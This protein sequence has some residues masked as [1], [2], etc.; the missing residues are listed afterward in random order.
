[1]PMFTSLFPRPNGNYDYS[2]PLHV[3]RLVSNTLS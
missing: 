3:L 2:M 1:M